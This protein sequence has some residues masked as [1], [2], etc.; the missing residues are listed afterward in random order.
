[1]GDPEKVAS[2]EDNHTNG[3]QLDLSPTNPDSIHDPDDSVLS[4]VMPAPVPA[5]A[6]PPQPTTGGLSPDATKAMDDV[7]YSDVC[8]SRL[9]IH[10]FLA[11]IGL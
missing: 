9:H 3:A 5:P 10:G 2:T 1:M 11:E 8:R 4:P 6:P 7:L